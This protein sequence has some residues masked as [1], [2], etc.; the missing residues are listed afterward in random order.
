MIPVAAEEN[1]AVHG[2]TGRSRAECTS[3]ITQTEQGWGFA[4]HP[5][6]TDAGEGSALLL[7]QLLQGSAMGGRCFCHQVSLGTWQI[8]SESPAHS[9]QHW[10]VKAVQGDV[11]GRPTFSKQ[12]SCCFILFGFIS[13]FSESVSTYEL[14]EPVLFPSK[15][16]QITL[17]LFHA[18]WKVLNNGFKWSLLL[19]ELA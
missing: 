10:E 4:Q 15:R 11:S 1:A 8:A 17:E 12:F 13:L 7:L 9:Q 6:V 19:I 5:S 16:N 2:S 18:S 14:F 3:T